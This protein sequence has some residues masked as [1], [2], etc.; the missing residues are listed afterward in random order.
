MGLDTMPKITNTLFETVIKNL[1]LAHFEITSDSVISG[2]QV[3]QKI[4][5]GLL[6][7]QF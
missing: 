6:I 4:S 7:K 3:W 2:N 5:L 1:P